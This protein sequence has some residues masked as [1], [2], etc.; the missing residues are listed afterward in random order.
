MGGVCD[1]TDVEA[2]TSDGGLPNVATTASDYL[3]DGWTAENYLF[4]NNGFVIT[5]ASTSWWGS[6]YGAIV[7]PVL[8]LTGNDKVTVVARV[9]SYYPSNYGV[10]QVRIS[11]GSAYSDYTL[12]TDDEEDFQEITVVLNCSSSDQ[13]RVQARANYVAI[14]SVYI[15]PGDITTEAKLRALDSGDSAYRLITEITD[16]FYTVSNLE[17]A[18]T[19]IYKVKALYVD[20]S[21][22]AWSN[23]E[24]VTLFESGHGFEPGDVNHDGSVNISDVTMLID[25]LLGSSEEGCDICADVN[26][27]GQVNISDVTDLIDRLLDN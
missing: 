25:L 15:Y 2:V 5:G 7:S 18:G 27:D 26:L 9:K 23:V 24:V 21:E 3:P 12:T 19:Y 16:R 8:D 13:V 11:T 4:V 20:G 22:S 10:G 17:P 1:L 6:T 14:E